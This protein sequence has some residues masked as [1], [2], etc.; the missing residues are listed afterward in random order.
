MGTGSSTGIEV[1]VKIED[2]VP[3]STLTGGLVELGDGTLVVTDT[4][5]FI[6]SFA[7]L[8]TDVDAL[9][10]STG[11][12]ADLVMIGRVI[13]IDILETTTSLL[14]AS[15]LLEVGTNVCLSLD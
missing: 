8:I 12:L 3:P 7:S 11:G 5:V 1:T 14:D 15:T 9:A 2:V 13:D 10:L 4:D 6:N